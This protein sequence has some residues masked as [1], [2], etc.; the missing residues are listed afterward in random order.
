MLP[1]E[2]YSPPSWSWPAPCREDGHETDLASLPRK[3]LGV[4]HRQDIVG[5]GEDLRPLLPDERRQGPLPGGGEAAGPRQ[6]P[7]EGLREIRAQQGFRRRPDGPGV[8]ALTAEDQVRHKT[9]GLKDLDAALGKALRRGAG[10]GEGDLQHQVRPRADGGLRP[11]VLGQ[12]REVPPLDEVPAHGADHRRLL[13]Q[14]GPDP[15]QLMAVSPVKGIVLCY[16]T[17]CRHANSPRSGNKKMTI[18]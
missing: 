17:S 3:G 2:G 13:P 4:L 5:P 15:P 6:F 9:R 7:P 12:Q 18:W 1:A 16:D 8:G 10:P 14:K 11:G